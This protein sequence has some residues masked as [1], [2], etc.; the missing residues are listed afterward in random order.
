LG[1]KS[2]RRLPPAFLAR[3]F[4]EEAFLKSYVQVILLALVWSAPSF[5]QKLVDPSKVAPEFREAAEKR[6]AEQMRQRDCAKKAEAE[7]ITPRD[8]T[9][10]LLNCLKA[11]EAAEAAKAAQTA[12]APKASNAAETA[13]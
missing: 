9:P 1:G 8:R 10:Y 4:Q 7:K 5:A 13:K 3:E 2:Y 12:E 11:A 6:L